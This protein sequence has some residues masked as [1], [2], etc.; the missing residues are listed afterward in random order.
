MANGPHPAGWGVPGDW[1][2]YFKDEPAQHLA[3]MVVDLAAAAW[4]AIDR[5]QVLEWLLESR[6]Q[7]APGEIEA[8]KPTPEQELEL[9]ARRDEFLSQMFQT[10]NRTPTNS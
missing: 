1:Q 3:E 6:G 10:F 8:F 5:Q 9:T 4:V 7:L 2:Q